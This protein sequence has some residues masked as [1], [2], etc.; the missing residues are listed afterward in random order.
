M[1]FNQVMY[2][3]RFLSSG[4]SSWLGT[5][6]YLPQPENKKKGWRMYIDYLHSLT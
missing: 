1:T 4:C 2:K 6:R 5:Q 3:A